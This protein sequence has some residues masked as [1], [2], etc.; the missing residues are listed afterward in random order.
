MKDWIGFARA[1]RDYFPFVL[2]GMVVVVLL[3]AWLLFEAWRR[4]ANQT[5]THRLRR[6]GD[7]LETARAYSYR[8]SPTA[9][10][11]AP[12]ETVLSRRWIGRGAAATTSDG[13]CLLIVDAVIPGRR[14]AS[15][16][17]R[18]DGWPG[19]RHDVKVGHPLEV[20][21]NLGTYTLDVEGVTTTDALVSVTLKNRHSVEG[22]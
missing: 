18:L 3:A 13:G 22:A 9:P 12:H 16:N 5:E 21:G 2:F 15:I 14:S 7:R 10:Q 19:A 6:K 4:T 20:T 11:D 8:A 17:V 1:A